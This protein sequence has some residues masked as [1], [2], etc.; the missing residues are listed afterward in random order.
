MNTVASAT[1]RRMVFASLDFMRTK[2]PPI[3]LGTASIVANAITP[4]NNHHHHHHQEEEERR[5]QL[6]HKTWAV[7]APDFKVEDVIE[8]IHTHDDG[9]TDLAFGAFIWNERPLQQ[10]MRRLRKENFKGSIMLGGAQV[11]YADAGTLES[12]YP[13]ANVFVRGRRRPSGAHR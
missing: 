7:N 2:D 11:T 9:R 13:S 6:L 5:G 1:G 8:Y 10:I 3:A 4:N 12:C